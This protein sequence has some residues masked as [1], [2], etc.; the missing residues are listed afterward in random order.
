ME[1]RGPLLRGSALGEAAARGLRTLR[2]ASQPRAER[3]REDG[4]PRR[5]EGTSREPLAGT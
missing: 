4:A 1:P 3:A 5:R 2:R